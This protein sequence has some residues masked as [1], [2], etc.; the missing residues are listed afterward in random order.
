MAPRT[1]LMTL[2]LRREIS[3]RLR[4]L[5]DQGRTQRVTTVLRKMRA[6]GYVFCA[7]CR[8]W[9]VRPCECGEEVG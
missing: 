1:D 9:D 3:R 4:K 8:L 6:E 7:S 5:I 2:E